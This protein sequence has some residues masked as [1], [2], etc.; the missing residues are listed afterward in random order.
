[1]GWFGYI[2]GVWRKK[3]KRGEGCIH[4]CLRHTKQS[5]YEVVESQTVCDGHS[6]G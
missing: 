2:I 6:S 1:M 3:R 4:L 5:P